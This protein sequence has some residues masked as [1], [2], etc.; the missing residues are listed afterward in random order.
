MLEA[1]RFLRRKAAA[2]D[3]A[4]TVRQQHDLAEH[5]T[6]VQHLVRARVMFHNSVEVSRGGL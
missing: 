5:S 2:F 6:F 4:L 3:R 1:A